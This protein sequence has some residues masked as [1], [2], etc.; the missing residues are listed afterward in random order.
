MIIATIVIVVLILVL[1]AVL[2][3]PQILFYILIG[4]VTSPSRYTSELKSLHED[5]SHWVNTDVLAYFPPSI[6]TGASDI[7]FCYQTP[8][9]DIDFQLR[10]TIQP[11]DVAALIA[12]LAP[13]AKSISHGSEDM[14]GPQVPENQQYMAGLFL[15]ADGTEGE[16]PKQF[17]I[18]VMGTGHGKNNGS[19]DFVYGV[20]VDPQKND[21]LYWQHGAATGP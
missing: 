21:V 11:S 3:G 16:L 10:C 7:Q 13:I 12:K 20:A 9:G 8:P 15:K 19:W 17:I 18:Y 6:P 4:P 2:A 5:Y 14:Y 1:V